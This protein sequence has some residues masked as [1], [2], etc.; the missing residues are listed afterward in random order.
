MV[1]LTFTHSIVILYRYAQNKLL[2]TLCHVLSKKQ[3]KMVYTSNWN[4]GILLLYQNV[5]VELTLY[6][7]VA[8]S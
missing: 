4:I 6:D 7:Y 2:I 1:V 3:Y 8:E 5:R